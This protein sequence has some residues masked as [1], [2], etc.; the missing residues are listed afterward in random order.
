MFCFYFSNY[1]TS[2][3]NTCNFSSSSPSTKTYILFSGTSSSCPNQSGLRLALHEEADDDEEEE[4]QRQ[5]QRVVEFTVCIPSLSLLP[6][7]V[8]RKSTSPL[9]SVSIRITGEKHT[10]SLPTPCNNVPSTNQIHQSE[11]GSVVPCQTK[12]N[13]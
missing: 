8:T 4:E 13:S 3:Q 2:F 10:G 5:L 9:L 7:R 6:H 11:K 1:S 12:S